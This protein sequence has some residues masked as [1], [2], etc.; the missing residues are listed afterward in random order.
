MAPADLDLA[1]PR[2]CRRLAA[3]I[4]PQIGDGTLQPGCP[5][6]SIASLSQDH[7]HARQTC[8]KALRILEGEGLLARIP[9]LGYYVR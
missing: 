3:L 6:P 9:E 7:G 2:A 5:A 8:S 1:D 4:R